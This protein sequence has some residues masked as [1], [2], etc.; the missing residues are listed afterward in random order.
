MDWKEIFIS[1]TDWESVFN[2]VFRTFFMFVI[3]LLVLRFSGKRGV[4]QLSVYELAFILGLG[5]AAGDPMFQLDI[6]LIQSVLVFAVVLI[7]YKIITY[8]MSLNKKVEHVLEGSPVYIIKDGKLLINKHEHQS[9]SQDE[10]FAELRIQKVR[11]LGQVEYALLEI[12]G[13][14]SILFYPEKEVRY[15]LPVYPHEYKKAENLYENHY[16]SCMQCGET[17]Q[18]AAAVLPCTSCGHKEW[19]VALN[20]PVTP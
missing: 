9:L 20:M 13:E 19:A 5:S 17:I 11:H 1:N 8:I 3:I 18:L 6:P 2:I 12:N 14:V 16:Y 10:F 7:F 15:G 4:R